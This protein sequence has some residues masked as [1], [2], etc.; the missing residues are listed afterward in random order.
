MTTARKTFL[1]IFLSCIVATSYCQ[2]QKSKPGNEQTDS[3]IFATQI[4][5]LK[6]Y[7]AEKKKMDSIFN[8][9]GDVARASYEIDNGN[10]DDNEQKDTLTGYIKEERGA[11]NVIAYEVKFDCKKKKIISVNNELDGVDVSTDDN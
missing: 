4:M 6:E 8:K 9:T 2:A 7:K 5:M 3:T 10:S 11:I 1:L